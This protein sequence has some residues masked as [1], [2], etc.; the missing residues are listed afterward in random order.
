MPTQTT[1]TRREIQ[2]QAIQIREHKTLTADQKTRA[3]AE[4]REMWDYRI[5]NGLN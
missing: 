3:L 2:S 1:M 4:L 5:A